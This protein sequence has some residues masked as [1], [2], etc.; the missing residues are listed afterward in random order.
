MTIEQHF[1]EVDTQNLAYAVYLNYTNTKGGSYSPES[2]FGMAALEDSL[3]RVLSTVIELTVLELAENA[4]IYYPEVP[5]NPSSGV[6]RYFASELFRGQGSFSIDTQ[7]PFIS[8]GSALTSTSVPFACDPEG[9]PLISPNLLDKVLQTAKTL[10]EGFTPTQLLD[11]DNDM[12]GYWRRFAFTM[13]FKEDL[14]SLL[15]WDAP[16]KNLT[17][18][19]LA[20]NI[21]YYTD[22]VDMF[23]LLLEFDGNSFSFPGGYTTLR[24]VYTHILT[25][26]APTGGLYAGLENSVAYYDA[27]L[28][29][30]YGTL[31][32]TNLPEKVAIYCTARTLYN[33]TPT[34][35]LAAGLKAAITAA[36]PSLNQEF[37]WFITSELPVQTKAYQRVFSFRL[38]YGLGDVEVPTIPD[39]VTEDKTPTSQPIELIDPEPEIEEETRKLIEEWGRKKREKLAELIENFNGKDVSPEIFNIIGMDPIF[40]LVYE[41]DTLMVTHRGRSVAIIYDPKS[42]A[43]DIESYKEYVDTLLPE[44]KATLAVELAEKLTEELKQVP[45]NSSE[46]DSLIRIVEEVVRSEAGLDVSPIA[47]AIN[48]RASEVRDELVKA[49]EDAT[50]HSVGETKTIAEEL[51]KEI[52]TYQGLDIDL[53]NLWWVIV[54]TLTSLRVEIDAQIGILIESVMYDSVVPR[55]VITPPYDKLKTRISPDVVEFGTYDVPPNITY[56]LAFNNLM[57]IIRRILDNRTITSED[58][59]VLAQLVRGEITALPAG[60]EHLEL[61]MEK[62]QYIYDNLSAFRE[63]YNT[64]KAW[65]NA[66][67]KTA[68]DNITRD[69]LEVND[70][71]VDS[72]IASTEELVE[73]ATSYHIGITTVLSTP[74]VYKYSLSLLMADKPNNR[75][76]YRLIGRDLSNVL[77]SYNWADLDPYVGQGVVEGSVTIYNTR[78]VEAVLQEEELGLVAKTLINK[79]V[80]KGYAAAQLT[81]PDKTIGH[82]VSLYLGS[83]S[84]ESGVTIT[85]VAATIFEDTRQAIASKSFEVE[86]VLNAVYSGDN[87][88]V[89]EALNRVADKREVYLNTVENYVKSVV[90]SPD[91]EPWQKDVLETALEVSKDLD[92]STTRPYLANIATSPIPIL[93]P[94]GSVIPEERPQAIGDETVTPIDSSTDIILGSV[95]PGLDSTPS[96]TRIP[97][98]KEPRKE[99]TRVKYGDLLHRVLNMRSG[100]SLV[101]DDASIDLMLQNYSLSETYPTLYLQKIGGASINKGA[102]GPARLTLNCTVPGSQKVSPLKVMAMALILADPT[103]YDKV[104]LRLNLDVY[105]YAAGGKSLPIV[106]T[107]VQTTINYEEMSM[108]LYLS[109]YVHEAFI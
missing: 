29:H 55:E 39:E 56:G 12:E 57:T 103:I 75:V 52:T 40:D 23:H 59:Q 42:S 86:E 107:E 92:V 73:E 89:E 41:N 51:V 64:I 32:V 90:R 13:L 104:K 69:P 72:S 24:T 33:N 45:D 31:D 94:F 17:N 70:T 101:V 78:S 50:E 43:L 14:L 91:I 15:S 5:L 25:K 60:K 1:K 2:A 85:D 80:E 36:L 99:S 28:H 4:G 20:G 16:E 46:L 105:T 93:P 82:L 63:D 65:I 11:F 109:G 34:T 8:Q 26:E 100:L 84:D 38:S 61:I 66:E 83:V 3:K 37:R 108:N 9:F 35:P 19:R 95:L 54:N 10:G 27:R 87:E 18:S 76:I 49:I 106:F 71:V 22:N 81:T 62:G 88:A 48:D 97:V 47:D 7:A 21:K 74:V 58:I 102:P 77:D 68:L 30:S 6:C 44:E 53:L 96:Y 79:L 98:F 67:L